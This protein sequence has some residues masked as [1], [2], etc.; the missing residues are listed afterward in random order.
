MKFWI[1][2]IRIISDGLDRMKTANDQDSSQSQRPSTTPAPN[3]KNQVNNPPNF[4]PSQSQRPSTPP[5][6]ENRSGSN[7]LTQLESDFLDDG[8]IYSYD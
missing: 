5:N 8:K 3:R 2:H 4:P 6:Y 7:F 1:E